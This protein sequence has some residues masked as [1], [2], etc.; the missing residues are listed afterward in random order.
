MAR[1]LPPLSGLKSLVGN[2]LPRVDTRGYHL[3]PLPGLDNESLP[4]PAFDMITFLQRATSKLA[5][6]A[7]IEA[8]ASFRRRSS[9]RQ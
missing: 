9:S 1:V 6:R 8:N 4:V 2:A 5:L 7:G 3:S